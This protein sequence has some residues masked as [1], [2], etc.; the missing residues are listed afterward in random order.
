[1]FSEVSPGVSA[2][3]EFPVAESDAIHPSEIAPKSTFLP[4]DQPFSPSDNLSRHPAILSRHPTIFSCRVAI[5]R[6]E[7]R[8]PAAQLSPFHFLRVSIRD[9]NSHSLVTK[10]RRN[11]RFYSMK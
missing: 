3:R 10:H 9:N 2:V 11:K 6:R 5:L 4:G 1:L 8:P 7:R